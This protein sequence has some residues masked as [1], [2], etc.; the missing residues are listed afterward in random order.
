V[1]RAVL[2]FDRRVVS[3]ELNAARA[4]DVREIRTR[5]LVIDVDVRGERLT[6]YADGKLPRFVPKRDF[7]QRFG[8]K[9]D[10]PDECDRGSRRK[11]ANGS[12]SCDHD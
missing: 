1:I 4:M 6:V 7:R 8:R 5:D 12:K 2:A 9:S 11:A 10:C 3:R